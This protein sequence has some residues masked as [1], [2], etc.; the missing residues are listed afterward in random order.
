MLI[1]KQMT[2]NAEGQRETMRKKISVG[3]FRWVS[4][5]FGWFRQVSVGFGRFRLNSATPLER[6][7]NPEIGLYL[8]IGVPFERGSGIRGCCVCRDTNSTTPL[9]RNA[10][11]EIGTIIPIIIIPSITRITIIS[12]CV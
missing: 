9:E 2:L 7:A 10:N 5:G 8:W 12:R 11:P 3:G 4:V 1:A 6:N